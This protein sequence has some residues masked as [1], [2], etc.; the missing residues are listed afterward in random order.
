MSTSRIEAVASLVGAVPDRQIA[1]LVGVTRS[2]VFRYRKRRGIPPAAPRVAAPAAR[3]PA[4]KSRAKRKRS[5]GRVSSAWIRPRTRWAVYARDRGQ[6][7]WCGAADACESLD[8]IWPR[9]KHA[10]RPN[11]PRW[12]VTC[13]LRCNRQR[14]RLRISAW[15]RHLRAAGHDLREV[16]A[17]MARGRLPVVAAHGDAYRQRLVAEATRPLDWSEEA[18][19]EVSVGADGAIY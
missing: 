13:C 15:L 6:C 18:L 2:A 7:V 16:L 17:R 10:V 19:A 11:D 14:K 12:L 9:Q 3:K 8:H 1:G 5:H 4:E